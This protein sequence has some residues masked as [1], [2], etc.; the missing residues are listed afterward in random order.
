MRLLTLYT[1][2]LFIIFSSCVGPPEYTDGL[3][4]NIPAITNESDYFSLSIL[5]YDY[6]DNN[7]WDLLFAGAIEDEILTTLVIK[8]LNISQSDSTYL[9]LVN[10]EGDTIIN[11]GVF[12]DI[13]Y[14]SQ[15]SLKHIGF[16][17]KVILNAYNFT[18]RLDFQIIKFQQ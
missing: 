7:E 16:P 8:D 6:T 2:T 17:T 11:G 5:G 1:V 10:D 9:Y 12:N 4:E 14:T 18:G 13:I 15:D 3:L